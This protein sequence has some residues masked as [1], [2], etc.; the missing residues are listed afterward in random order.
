M[1]HAD[2]LRRLQRKIKDLR[3]SPGRAYRPCQRRNGKVKS[4]NH[5][6]ALIPHCN[7]RFITQGYNS[8][9]EMF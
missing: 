5:A 4:A 1:D 9:R 7:Y 2:H 8:A 3:L 6:A